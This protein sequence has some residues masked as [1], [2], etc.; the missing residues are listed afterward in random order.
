MIRVRDEDEL[1]M[2]MCVMYVSFAVVV[3]ALG[4]QRHIFS[5]A[6]QGM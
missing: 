4:C 3:L 5:M 6:F 2:L 1:H